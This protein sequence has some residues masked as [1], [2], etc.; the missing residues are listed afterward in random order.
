M[1]ITFTCVV[2]R[3]NLERITKNYFH[4]DS[5]TSW[6]KNRLQFWNLV[7]N[8]KEHTGIT[9]KSNGNNSEIYWWWSRSGF[10]ASFQGPTHLFQ[11]SK[12]WK[13]K[14]NLKEL[15]RWPAEVH[16]RPNSFL[17]CKMGFLQNSSGRIR[18][19]P[20]AVWHARHTAHA[21]HFQRPLIFSHYGEL[22]HSQPGKYNGE[23]L[24]LILFPSRHNKY[25]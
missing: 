21:W 19:E 5:E 9:R 11:Q 13:F 8:E 14:A 2:L 7:H 1:V 25:N 12:S 17:T 18:E 10:S 16:K 3:I 23:I 6:S 22:Y 24:I 15:Y 4:H 20:T